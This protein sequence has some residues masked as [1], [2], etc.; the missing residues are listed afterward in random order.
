MTQ[1]LKKQLKIFLPPLVSVAL[2][3]MVVFWFIVPEFRSMIHMND[4]HPELARLR[5]RLVLAGGGLLVAVL[6]VSGFMVLQ[7]IAFEKERSRMER[8]LRKLAST[9]PLTGA[10]N[11]R[12][13][14]QVGD[15]ELHRHQRYFRE[16]AVLVM[17]IDHF[18]RI[19]ATF[20]HPAGDTVLLKLANT[21]K[22]NLRKSDL[23]GR[24]GGEAFAIVLVETQ[25]EAA[26]EVADRLRRRLA[27][28]QILV[29]GGVPIQFTVSIGITSARREDE[30]LD[31]LVKRA[32]A[33]MNMAKQKGRNRVETDEDPDTGKPLTQAY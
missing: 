18:K 3:G 5:G 23:F 25:A 15:M 6:L 32:Y 4:A 8:R 29:E 30:C 9:D 11:R 1:T 26:M 27:D 16:L 21:C 7:G 14:W 22:S 28:D 19:N 12:H 2:F 24:I 20:G 10:L 33:A 17:D 13:F 31:D